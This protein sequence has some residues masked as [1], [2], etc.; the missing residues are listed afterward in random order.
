MST[1]IYIEIIVP[2]HKDVLTLY[3]LHSLPIFYKRNDQVIRNEII[4]P[5][6]YI[7]LKSQQ[8]PVA[9]FDDINYLNNTKL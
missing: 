8:E 5:S 4:I 3:R 6:K 1:D 9:L 7:R 2:T